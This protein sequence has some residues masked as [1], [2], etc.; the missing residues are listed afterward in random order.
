MK[1]VCGTYSGMCSLN[2]I[3][4]EL[5]SLILEYTCGFRLVARLVCQLWR[6]L[7]PFKQSYQR[8]LAEELV[9]TDN[10]VMI[11]WLLTQTRKLDRDV[12]FHLVNVGNLSLF[13]QADVTRYPDVTEGQVYLICSALA[14][15]K[16]HLDFLELTKP[17]WG[18]L[19]VSHAAMGGH[20]DVMISVTEVVRLTSTEDRL[21]VI[22]GA[23]RGGHIPVLEWL[24]EQ[25]FISPYLVD[26][27]PA[28]MY[29]HLEALKWLSSHGVPMSRSAA[30]LAVAG[31]Y[32]EIL[33]HLRE[34][35]P[36][37][38]G[39]GL[40]EIALLTN[41]YLTLKWLI[42][43]K[44]DEGTLDPGVIIDAP[45]NARSLEVMVEYK[46]IDLDLVMA[47]AA[48][49]QRLDVMKRLVVVGASV[50]S[51]TKTLFM[52]GLENGSKLRREGE[53]WFKSLGY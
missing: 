2:N 44:I 39:S 5:V 15:S 3:H 19:T 51:Q 23:L 22:V 21:Y 33:S 18:A 8:E 41:H 47:T 48:Q 9:L 32:I 42:D 50:N 24:Y 38:L 52:K 46:L 13:K 49:R 43:K 4:P 34:E 6:K 11:E 28:A 1:R 14:A 10:R 7:L 17:H 26:P 36:T 27:A 40:R 31:G 45:P 20:L 37:T 12:L 30:E 53:M 16:H 25:G 35:H 29:G